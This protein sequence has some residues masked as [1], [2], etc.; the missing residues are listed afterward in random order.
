MHVCIQLR[1]SSDAYVRT[2][3]ERVSLG[4]L[5]EAY[6]YVHASTWVCEMGRMGMGMGMGMGMLVGMCTQLS[7]LMRCTRDAHAQAPAR[8]STPS[9][10]CM[11][12][13]L[14]V[15]RRRH[16]HLHSRHRCASSRAARDGAVEPPRALSSMHTPIT[17]PPSAGMHISRRLC[18]HISRRLCMH[19]SRRLCMHISRRA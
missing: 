16:A 9:C 10:V 1:R 17:T 19:I 7:C 4:V 18:M 2:E 12:V 3:G 15:H 13:C 11:Y 14:Y 6:V 5:M 8:A